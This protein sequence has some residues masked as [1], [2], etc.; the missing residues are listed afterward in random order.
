VFATIAVFLL[1]I[2]VGARFVR[3]ES[4]AWFGILPGIPVSLIVGLVV[5]QLVFRKVSSR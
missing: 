3:D 1:M 2:F 5:F 4:G